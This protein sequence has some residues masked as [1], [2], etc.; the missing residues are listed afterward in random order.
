MDDYYQ[1]LGLR[2]GASPNE[3]RQAYRDLARVWH[4]DRF[5]HDARLCKLAEE[6]LKEINIAYEALSRGLTYGQSGKQ[7]DFT[8]ARTSRSPS[9]EDKARAGSRAERKNGPDRPQ[10]K[11]QAFRNP[12]PA[13]TEHVE[14][15]FLSV[16]LV[17]AVIVIVFLYL[18]YPVH[19]PDK[20]GLEQA[21][22][23][24][25]P[26]DTSKTQTPGSKGPVTLPA[27]D[28]SPRET[29]VRIAPHSPPHKAPSKPDVSKEKKAVRQEDAP[30]D[31]AAI[32]MP[33]DTMEKAEILEHAE[34]DVSPKGDEEKGIG[35]ESGGKAG[36]NEDAT[37][38]HLGR[39]QNGEFCYDV[40]SVHHLTPTRFAFWTRIKILGDEYIRQTADLKKHTAQYASLRY[41]LGY[42]EIDTER[43]MWRKIL[44]KY[45]DER[46]VSL[47]IWNVPEKWNY[48]PNRSVIEKALQEI[49]G[50]Q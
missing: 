30:Q 33:S 50:A 17:F 43:R 35:T 31:A 22:S 32:Q 16:V 36:Q 12:A 49:K 41:L 24:A 2:P 46:Y 21:A 47:H 9:E 34:G 5:V 18:I 38:R 26:G 6:K 8:R 4:P 20:A 45:T 13:R 39:T 40:N 42:N 1:V 15:I 11:E 10:Q 14:P 29:S 25:M 19:P 23:D 3:I 28:G 37:W 48:I 7:G 27:S 44:V